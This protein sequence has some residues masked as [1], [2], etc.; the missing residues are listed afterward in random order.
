[1]RAANARSRR[2]PVR[3]ESPPPP[4]TREANAG[5]VSQRRQTSQ[6]LDALRLA[7]LVPD[8]DVAAGVYLRLDELVK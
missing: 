4:H 6:E 7:L 5:Q 1:M 8:D 2:Q 3:P